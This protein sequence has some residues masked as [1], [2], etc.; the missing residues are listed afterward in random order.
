MTKQE[1]KIQYDIKYKI[2]SEQW[3]INHKWLNGKIA[4][5]AIKI[6]YEKYGITYLELAKNLDRW[7][8]ALIMELLK[9]M[10]K[11]IKEIK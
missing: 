4:K 11:I 8:F 7:E 10:E 3:K 9:G 6:F 1:F 2:I 5:K